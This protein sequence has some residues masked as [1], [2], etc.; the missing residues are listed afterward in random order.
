M[1]ANVAF[2][3]QTLFN[4]DLLVEAAPWFSTNIDET[5]F[6]ELSPNAGLAGW[7]Y[8]AKVVLTREIEFDAP[9]ACT[10]LGVKPS[11]GLFKLIVILKTSG[12]GER[13]IA[14]QQT[15][16]GRKTT[17]EQIKI[18][19]DS[20]TVCEQITLVT[21]I[22]LAKSIPEQFYAPS[23]EG[24]RLW[25]DELPFSIEGSNSR[26]S[27]RDVD[28]DT[29]SKLPSHVPWHLEWQ[30]RLL[31]YSFNSV[32]SLLINS[33]RPDFLARIEEGEEMLVQQLM[34]DIATQIC[35]YML[36]FDDFVE[37]EEPFPEGSL[38]SVVASWLSAVFPESS[39]LELQ[40]RYI[41]DPGLVSTQLRSLM[42]EL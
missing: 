4:T 10:Y 2:P 39:H 29:T 15:L 7:S 25:N 6:D 1:K 17:T 40:Q 23:R 5:E 27:M 34:G 13:V 41:R 38:G 33:N 3:F 8:D 16:D 24:S 9:E 12:I 30:P 42:S 31:D 11:K 14:F 28:F 35:S 18:E 19:L 21:E 22:V 36:T 32:V 20:R 26:F 37:Q